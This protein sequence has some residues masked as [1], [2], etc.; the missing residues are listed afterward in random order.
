MTSWPTMMRIFF[1]VSFLTAFKNALTPICPLL[2]STTAA[3]K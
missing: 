1:T 2:R 3:P